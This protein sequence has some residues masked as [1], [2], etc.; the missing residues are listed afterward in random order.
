MACIDVVRA[1]MSAPDERDF[2][3]LTILP[4]EP[5]PGCAV[6]AVVTDERR[7]HGADGASHVR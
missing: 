3:S 2:P 6:Q 1:S 5:C 4:L 7:A